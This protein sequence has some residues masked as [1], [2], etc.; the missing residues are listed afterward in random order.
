MFFAFLGE[1]N[2]LLNKLFTLGERLFSPPI[3]KLLPKR[4]ESHRCVVN[5]FGKLARNLSMFFEVSQRG[6]FKKIA[7]RI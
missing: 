2:R 4:A 5:T 3:G 1:W 7:Y 6:S